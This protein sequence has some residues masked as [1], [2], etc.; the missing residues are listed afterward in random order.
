MLSSNMILGP[1]LDLVDLPSV[2]CQTI[3]TKAICRCRPKGNTTFHTETSLHHKADLI[4]TVGPCLRQMPHLQQS[5]RLG[6]H[7]T[8]VEDHQIDRAHHNSS[9]FTRTDQHHEEAIHRNSSD[10]ISSAI[11]LLRLSGLIQAKSEWEV[12]RHHSKV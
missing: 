11:R 5:L 7:W 9:D 12:R 4:H 10:L 8:M 2:E 3:T 6:V 1:D